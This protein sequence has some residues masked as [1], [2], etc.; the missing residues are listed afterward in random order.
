MTSATALLE[1]AMPAAPRRVGNI[2]QQA[3]HRSNCTNFIGQVHIF[4]NIIIIMINILLQ[5]LGKA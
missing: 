1:M 5:V 2:L 3:N 4:G